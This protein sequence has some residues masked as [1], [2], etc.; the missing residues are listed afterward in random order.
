MA[1]YDG[2]TLTDRLEHGSLP[3]EKTIDITTQM[4]NG[5][6]KAHEAGITHRDIKPAN[7]IVTK[8]GEVKIIDFGL[9]QRSDTPKITKDGETP[10]TIAY[11]SPEQLMGE[12]MDSRTDIWSLGVV[13]YE[14]LTGYLPFKGEYEHAVVYSILNVDPE[15]MT[16]LRT[17][18]QKN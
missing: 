14:M 2:E 9:A 4:I 1:Y 8:H 11:M 5:L 13:L 10:G 6:S 15:P 18:V 12:S 7:I 16:G 17:D 3:I